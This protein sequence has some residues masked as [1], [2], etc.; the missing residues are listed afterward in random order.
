MTSL[1]VCFVSFQAFAQTFTEGENVGGIGLGLGG[2]LYS[3]YYGSGIK[4]I[5][6][7]TLYY[8]HCVKGNLWDENS[9]IGVGA[10]LGY[11]SASTDYWKS[12]NIIIGA[13]G[14]LHYSFVENLDTYTGLMLGYDIASF[15]WKEID[16][17]SNSAGGF[18]WSWFVGARYYFN[19]SF[20]AFAELGYGI[21][22]LNLGVAMKF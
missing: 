6:A 8:E 5:P 19:E 13:R 17:G 20:G 2:N 12:S 1:V 22:T 16:L 11:A 14:A 15:K 9:S 4:R 18:T 10:I 3:G 7:I 21:A